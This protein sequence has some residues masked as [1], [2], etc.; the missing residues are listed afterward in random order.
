MLNMGN[1]TSV[2]ILSLKMMKERYGIHY[3]FPHQIGRISIS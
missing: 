1:L 2:G 3:D